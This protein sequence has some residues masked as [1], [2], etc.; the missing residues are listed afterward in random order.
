MEVTDRGLADVCFEEIG[1][2]MKYLSRDN[3]CPSE[4]IFPIQVY[5][6]IARPS[7]LVIQGRK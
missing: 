1:E 4:I 5:S 2:A 6:F 3:R 7:C